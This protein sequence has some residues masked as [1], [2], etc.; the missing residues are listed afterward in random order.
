MKLNYPNWGTNIIEVYPDWRKH[1][2]QISDAISNWWKQSTKYENRWTKIRDLLRSIT[3]NS[4]NYDEKFMKI[5]FNADDYLPLK[6]F[7]DLKHDN[8]C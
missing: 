7:R 3:N 8:S 4:D 2:K 1:W 6:N 5:K